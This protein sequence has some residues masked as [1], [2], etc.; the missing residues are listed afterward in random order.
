MFNFYLNQ[1][2]L[3]GQ[4]KSCK[5]NNIFFTFLSKTVTKRNG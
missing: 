1:F 3:H 5:E 2:F 4:F